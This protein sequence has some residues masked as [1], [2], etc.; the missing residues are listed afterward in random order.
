MTLTEKGKLRA[1]VGVAGSWLAAGL[2][3]LSLI[4]SCAPTPLPADDSDLNGDLHPRTMFDVRVKPQLL[5]SCAACHAIPQ[6]TVQPFLVAGSEYESITGYKS[7]IFLS[8]PAV[9]SLLLQKGMHEG[10]ALVQQ[11]F[12]EVQAWLEAEAANRP[13]ANGSKSGLLPTIPLQAGEFNMSFETLAPIL[14]AQANLTF[15]LEE[16]ESRIFRVSKLKLTA[17][18]IT[19]IR[20]KH[21]IFYFISAKGAG[22]DPAD[23]LAAT[24]VQ[25]EAGKS[26]TVGPGTV[27]LTQAPVNKLARIGVAFQLLERWNMGPTMEEKCKAFNLFN[28]AVKDQLVSCAQSCHSPGKNNV[29]NGAF[30]MSDA[31]SSDVKAL[32]Q[33]CLSTL[34]RIDRDQPANSILIKQITPQNLGGTPNHPF[35][36]TDAGA[37]TRFVNA[38]LAWAAG[39]K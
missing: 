13:G 17:G 33:L 31:G 12:Q 11:Q 34:G 4:A 29:A 35:K 27:L 3:I 18:S 22:P 37:R 19:G 26:A 8:S 7:G 23:S 9:M 20:L 15:T 5:Q 38:I 30:N 14:D 21:P 24:E 32:Q 39:E 28:P 25:V 10:P 16:D 1:T 36:Q 2:G 6:G